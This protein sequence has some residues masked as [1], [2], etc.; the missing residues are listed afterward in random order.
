LINE[1]LRFSFS[2]SYLFGNRDG[3]ANREVNYQL[4]NFSGRYSSS[5]GLRQWDHLYPLLFV[6]VVEALSMMF[7]AAVSGSLLF[8]FSMGD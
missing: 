6:I 3:E 8:G 4:V 7:S 1:I 2:W 5:H